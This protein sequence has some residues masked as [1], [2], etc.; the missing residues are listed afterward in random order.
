M[1]FSPKIWTIIRWA[2]D[3]VHMVLWAILAAWVAYIIVSI[4]RLSEAAAT[5]EHQRAQ[6]ISKEN[7]FYC[8]K[9]GMRP[10]THEYIIC[11]MDLNEIRAKVEERI[12]ED[13]NF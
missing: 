11:T 10:N 5:A 6:E 7:D 12:A 9:W 1:N 8:E 3:T 13:N 2:Y 4:P